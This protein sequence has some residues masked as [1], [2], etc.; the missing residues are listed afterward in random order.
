[1]LIA[2]RRQG[3]G[4]KVFA[5]NSVVN[6]TVGSA[7]A[8]LS[9][10]LSDG[11]ITIPGNWQ[12]LNNTLSSDT[13]TAVVT[14]PPKTALG[15][16]TVTFAFSGVNPDG[17]PYERHGAPDRQLDNPDGRELR[18]D[19]ARPAVAGEHHRRGAPALP[20]RR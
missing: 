19:R 13:L 15:T 11:T 14:V 12:N 7:T 6:V 9:A 18:H 1:M 3:G 2:A 17:N 5:N 16:G 20:V 4:E 8:G 10:S